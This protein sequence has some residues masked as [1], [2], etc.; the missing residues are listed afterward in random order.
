MESILFSINGNLRPIIIRKKNLRPSVQYNQ[1]PF[2]SEFYF[3]DCI[4]K[5]LTKELRKKRLKFQTQSTFNLSANE[6]NNKIEKLNEKLTK[7]D[8][9][10][11]DLLNID[12]FNNKIKL[13]YKKF[14][15]TNSNPNVINEVSFKFDLIATKHLQ[16]KP[17]ISNQIHISLNLIDKNK[18][19]INDKDTPNTFYLLNLLLMFGISAYDNGAVTKLKEIDK[20]YIDNGYFTINCT[21]KEAIKVFKTI[22]SQLFENINDYIEVKLLEYIKSNLKRNITVTNN[23]NTSIDLSDTTA[24]DKIR[25]LQIVGVLDFL[26]EKQPFNTSINSLASLLSAITGENI[27]TI[28]PY[29][30]PMYSKEVSQKNNP[31]NARKQVDKVV[32]QL[33]KIGF[34]P[35]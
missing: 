9:C 11:S 14:I 2:G 24:I 17:S 33:I 8:K 10:T 13:N 29:L 6:V 22:N 26:R 19:F 1:T 32:N 27:D 31:L 30:N 20:D 7:S 4:E 21:T 35:K 3:I 18:N 25:F 23:E 28:Q 16:K 34:T 12:Y 15:H 5:K